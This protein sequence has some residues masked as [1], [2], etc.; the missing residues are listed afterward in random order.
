ARPVVHLNRMTVVDDVQWNRFVVEYQSRQVGL[1]RSCNVDRR[2][3][4]TR[5]T[6]GIRRVEFSPILW[7]ILPLV[8]PMGWRLL[9]VCENRNQQDAHYTQAEASFIESWIFHFSVLPR[10]QT[11]SHFSEFARISRFCGCT[12]MT[13]WRGASISA[14]KKKKIASAMGRIENMMRALPL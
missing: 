8:F 11:A 3:R 7:A 4:V 10:S 12:M 1:F 14:T 13:P 2:L 6:V 9:G 5:R